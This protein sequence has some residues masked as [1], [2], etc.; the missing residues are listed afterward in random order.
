M[1]YSEILQ[2]VNFISGFVDKFQ[3][4]IILQQSSKK[5]SYNKV[6]PVK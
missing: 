1:R 5:I 6:V 3:V 4:F 2:I